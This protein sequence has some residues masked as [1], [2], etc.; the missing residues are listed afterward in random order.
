MYKYIKYIIMYATTE[1]KLNGETRDT[2]DS[3]LSHPYPYTEHGVSQT[4]NDRDT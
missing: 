1:C 3:K 4:K 2:N